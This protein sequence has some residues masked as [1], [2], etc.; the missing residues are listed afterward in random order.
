MCTE[1]LAKF[2]GPRLF[3]FNICLFVLCQSCVHS[4]LIPAVTST[5]Q[6]RFGFSSLQSGYIISAY[7]IAVVVLVPF[8]SYFGGKSHKP[9]FL[10]VSYFV[11]SCSILLFAA[12]HAFAGAYNIGSGSIR[13]Y[14]LCGDPLEC[15]A[16]GNAAQYYFIFVLAH[17]I[18]AFGGATL[19]TV[20]PAFFDET[21]PKTSVP[22]Y[23]AIFYSIAAVGPAI[24]YL[25]A[26]VFLDTW[27]DGPSKQPAGVTP[28]SAQFVGNWWLGFVVTGFLGLLFCIPLFFFD[29][30]LGNSNGTLINHVANANDLEMPSVAA[31]KYAIRGN[32][33]E[34]LHNGADSSSNNLA[35]RP[36]SAQSTSSNV[37]IS[38][39][40]DILTNK[41]FM[42][43]TMTST[44]EAFIVSGFASWLPTAVQSLFSLSA[45]TA[46]F[47]VG[48]V[49]ILGATSGIAVGGWLSNKLEGLK[50]QL[51]MCTISAVIC[52]L[53]LIGLLMGCDDPFIAGINTPMKSTSLPLFMSNTSSAVK[54]TSYIGYHQGMPLEARCNANCQCKTYPY[55]PICANG[56][57]YYNPCF[58][59]CTMMNPMNGS[60][61]ESK[62]YNCSCVAASASSPTVGL[63]IAVGGRCP[64]TCNLLIPFMV[65]LFFIMFFTFIVNV[66]ST[67]VLMGVIQL[68]DRTFALGIQNAIYRT[69]GSIPAPIIFGALMDRVCVMW[70]YVTCGHFGEGSCSQFNSGDLRRT[71]VLLALIPKAFAILLYAI[72]WKFQSTSKFVSVT[73]SHRR[74][75]ISLG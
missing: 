8:I 7:D 26:G 52:F 10:A 66:P 64:S 5:L 45:S 28:T 16:S 9:R 43:T 46:S 22:G 67:T 33:T 37:V 55:S 15:P 11:L 36:D 44:F 49:V 65:L 73:G 71:F 38:K 19:Y 31:N 70:E 3:L 62:F 18:F 59:G 2:M 58:A 13:P 75:S 53:L 54:P 69:L 23:L 56:I 6:K 27:V 40:I 39:L 74:P 41:V 35:H 42:L 30:L 50:G 21:L 4:G 57:N 51:K 1:T 48:F 32:D 20:T 29:R 72:A 24:G 61:T 25:F 60:I 34:S 63:G 68:E 14:Q 47:V 17:A 12:P